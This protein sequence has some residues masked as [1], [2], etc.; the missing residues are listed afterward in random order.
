MKILVETRCML[1]GYGH[2]WLADT[3]FA[4]AVYL[5]RRKALPGQLR[6]RWT[7]IFRPLVRRKVDIRT[8]PA[9]MDEP[10]VLAEYNR[11]MRRIA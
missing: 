11:T 7:M 10:T 2:D 4:V 9:W 8:W 1:V 3:P 5:F 6:W